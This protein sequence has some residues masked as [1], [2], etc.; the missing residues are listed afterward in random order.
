MSN[1]KK[2]IT[3][4]KAQAL[5]KRSQALALSREMYDMAKTQFETLPDEERH[6]LRNELERIRTKHHLVIWHAIEKVERA[7]E[8]LVEEMMVLRGEWGNDLVNYCL[9][10]SDCT[11]EPMYTYPTIRDAEERHLVANPNWPSETSLFGT[12]SLNQ[13]PETVDTHTSQQST[14]K[15]AIQPDSQVQN[16]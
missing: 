5:Q 13:V 12:H 2:H 10:I 8:R 11:L 3:D 6:T 14:P 4:Q 1:L 7:T 16:I 15:K 9:D